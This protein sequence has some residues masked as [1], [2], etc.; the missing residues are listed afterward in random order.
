MN[1]NLYAL[2][3][4]GEAYRQRRLQEAERSRLLHE[5]RSRGRRAPGLVRPCPEPRP[6]ADRPRPSSAD[7]GRA[8]APTFLRDVLNPMGIYPHRPT[9]AVS[10]TLGKGRRRG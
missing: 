5:I 4:F 10:L 7:A 3:K 6:R 9:E 2:E 1:D 8:R